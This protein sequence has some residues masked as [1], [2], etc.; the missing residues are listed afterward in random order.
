MWSKFKTGQVGFSAKMKPGIPM[1]SSVQPLG[2]VLLR[3]MFGLR[4]NPAEY[5]T[6]A[7]N[8]RPPGS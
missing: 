6:A 3:E 5:P 8:R 1:N 7:G 2:K 4:N